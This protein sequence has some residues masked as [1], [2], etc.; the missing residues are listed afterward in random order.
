LI[1]SHID[2]KLVLSQR[3]TYKPTP[4]EARQC[5]EVIH[6]LQREF[7]LSATLAIDPEHA[8]VGPLVEALAD[9]GR[10]AR[11]S[12]LWN[13]QD[14]A[15]AVAALADFERRQQQQGARAVRVRSG[16]RVV[17]DG[18]TL[19]AGRDSGV[20]LRGLLTAA[21]GGQALRLTLDPGP[22]SGAVYYYLTVIEVPNAPPVTPENAGIAVERW[23]EPYDGAPG[24]RVA[25]AAEGELVRVRLRVTV[26]ATRHFVVLDD[27]L[28][29]GLEA[30]DL[31]LR[32][33][34][35]LP[36]PGAQAGDD[37]ERRERD[38]EPRWGYGTWDAGW[39]SPFD[40]REIRDDRVVYSAT[41][42]WPGTY[43]AT[44]VA[45]ATT[46]GTFV[47]PPAHAEEMYNPGVN[48]RSEGGTFTVT[49]RR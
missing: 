37:R 21:G 28:P 48:G 32:T 18:A 40:H 7:V 1:W 24:R 12:W 8:L 16:D 47:R 10:T 36:G 22:G 38:D 20:A 14:Y 9:H 46:P 15:S 17:L 6:E 34:A 2:K 3:K 44:Y 25:S 5:I 35:A 49:P 43:T 23:Y 42:L 39:W 27:A 26:P 31:S 45:R 41:V 19:A 4:E 11:S 30:V 29:A 33:A 13:T